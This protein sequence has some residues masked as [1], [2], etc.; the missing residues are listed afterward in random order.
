MAE[1]DSKFAGPVPDDGSP[2]VRA[3]RRRAGALLSAEPDRNIAYEV[4]EGVAW[5][6]LDRAE[7]RNAITTAM[8]GR[9]AE[10]FAAAEVDEAVRVIVLTGAG[11]AFC[12]GTDLS[13]ATAGASQPLAVGQPPLATPLDAAL[14]PVLAAIN[15]PAAGGGFELALASDL[16]IASSDA[17][18][19]LPEVTIGSLPGSGGTQRL[20]RATS[21]AFA[22]KML[23]T[24]MTIDAATALEWGIVSDVVA[25]G[26]LLGLAERLASKIASNAPLSVRAAKIAARA[27]A[28]EPLAVGLGIERRLWSTLATT[29]DR[30]EGR[31]AFREKR[32]PRFTGR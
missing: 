7:K 3:A 2:R 11:P 9:L 18:F 10:V 28:N 8:R 23:L 5:V 16:R 15:G 1:T 27:A 25:P 6:T 21:A 22:M 26:E 14:K 29:E 17:T 20:L 19:A 24:G 13:D 31:A 12:A 30:A 32:P 4:R